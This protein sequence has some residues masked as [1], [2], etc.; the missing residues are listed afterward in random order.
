MKIGFKL[1]AEDFGPRELVRQAILAEEAGMDFVEISD[2]YHPWLFNQHHSPFAWAVLA[3][4]AENTRHIQLGTG[5]TCPTMRYHPAIIAQASATIAVLSGGR[6]FLGIGAGERLN[7]HVIGEGWPS[8]SVRHKML[9]EALQIIRLLLSG[10]YHSF[11]GEYLALDSARVFDLPDTP[12]HIIV[13]V[14]GKKA[15]TVA[16]EFGDGIFSSEPRPELPEFFAQAGGTGPKFAEVPLAIG[17]NRE[18][19]LQRA[20]EQQ[21][22][23]AGGWKVMTELPNPAHFEAASK[24]VTPADMAPIISAGPDP[25]VHL[26]QIRKF[27]NAG[28]DHLALINV[29]GNVDEFFA[30]Y[31]QEL[32]G[33][34]RTLYL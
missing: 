28:F 16:A 10:G 24:F 34:L 20:C 14:G 6:H 5:V 11:D 27:A 3:S 8:V 26:D 32:A 29:G 9:R 25:T 18:I 2:H 17:A 23:A 13:A 21:R 22:F 19:A 15:A 1:M 12:P 4:I 33:P 7:E 30:Y 31:T